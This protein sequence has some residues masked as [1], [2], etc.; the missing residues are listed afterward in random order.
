[1]FPFT[2]CTSLLL[3]VLLP[4]I[5]ATFNPVMIHGDGT[6]GT[7]PSQEKRATIVQNIKASIQVTL[8]NTCGD[9]EWYRVAYLNMSDP[10]QRCPSVWRLSDS[11][12]CGIRMCRRPQSS[13]GSCP[14]TLYATSRQFSKVCGRAIGY[15][16]G[17]TDA[18]GYRAH[19]HPLD[20]YYVY[21]VSITHGMPCNHIWTFAAGLS[22]DTKMTI[23]PVAILVILATYSPRH[24]LE[25]TTTVSREIQQVHLFKVRFT[26][27][28][29]SGMESSV[30]VSTAA[31]ENLHHGSLW[32][33]LTPQLMTLRYAFA[34]LMPALMMSLFSCWRFIFSERTKYT[35]TETLF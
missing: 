5:T 22:E 21:G 32:S 10:S 14:A 35:Y 33:Y 30:K 11:N 2:V 28:I 9:G 12:N 3:M 4:A 29:H 25:T 19:S 27:M 34:Y 8:Q 16:V 13:S 15:Q 18:F 20:S 1:M 31:M 26:V 24:L 23:A 7:C 6:A 17:S